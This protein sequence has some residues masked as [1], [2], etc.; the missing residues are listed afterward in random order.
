[1]KNNILVLLGR[2]MAVRPSSENAMVASYSYGTTPGNDLNNTMSQLDM[3]KSLSENFTN[4][5]M[6]RSLDSS[7][8]DSSVLSNTLTEVNET[9]TKPVA[10]DNGNFYNEQPVVTSQFPMVTA[11]VRALIILINLFFIKV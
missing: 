8:I 3:T 9:P 10:V 2:V 6:T 4:D 5:L 7:L 11:S 1:M